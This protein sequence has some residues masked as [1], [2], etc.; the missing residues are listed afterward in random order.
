MAERISSLAR[1][2]TVAKGW[3]KEEFK[4]IWVTRLEKPQ[5]G[6][7]ALPFMNKTIGLL[8]TVFFINSVAPISSLIPFTSISK[9]EEEELNRRNT[10]LKLLKMERLSGIFE[11]EIITIL[12]AQI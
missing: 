5:S 10:T 3:F 12:D 7:L 9:L 2:L 1:T 11:I 6:R 8:S 4:R